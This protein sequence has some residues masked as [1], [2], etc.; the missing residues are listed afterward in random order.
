MWWCRMRRSKVLLI[1]MLA[2]VLVGGLSGAGRTGH[3]FT[4]V[5]TASIFH[6]SVS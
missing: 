2:A 5:A 3:V 1:G 6:E 4:D